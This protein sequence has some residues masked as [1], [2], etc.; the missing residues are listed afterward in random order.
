MENGKWK[1]EDGQSSGALA[2]ICPFAICHLPFA[3]HDGGVR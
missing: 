3:M 1:M 2:R